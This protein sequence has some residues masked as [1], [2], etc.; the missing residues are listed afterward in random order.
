MILFKI[1][2]L[3]LF[4]SSCKD[5]FKLQKLS[6]SVRADYKKHLTKLP[7]ISYV[8]LFSKNP[9]IKEADLGRMLFNDT[10]LSRN[11]DVSCATCHLSNH[12]FA[13]GN[14]ISVGSMGKGGPTGD[15]VGKTFGH[16]T[17]SVNRKLDSDGFG[18]YSSRKMFRNSL[19]TVNVG[20]RASKANNSGLLWDG[21]FGD[22]AFQVL[23]PIHTPEELCGQNPLVKGRTNIFAKGGILFK[24]PITIYQS[25]FT[26]TYTGASSNEIG[27]KPTLVEGIPLYRKNGALTIPNRNECLALAIAKINKVDEYRALF[28]EIYKTDN[29]TDKHL[30]AALAMFVSTHVSKKSKYDRFIEG[31]NSLNE[32][33]LLGLTLFMND[34]GNDFVFDGKKRKGAGCIKCHTPPLFDKNEY[35]SLGV[36]SDPAS[37]LSRP[38]FQENFNSGFFNRSNAGKGN[39]TKCHIKGVSFSSSNLYAPDVGNANSTF[40]D[41]S[42]FKFRVPT[43][44]NVIATFPYFHHGS[45]LASGHEANSI[46][47]R[48]VIALSNAVKYHLRGPVDVKVYGIKNYPKQFF[49]QFYQRDPFIPLYRQNF[50]FEQ[51]TFEYDEFEIKAIV[52]F[53]A[54]GLKDSDS[55]KTGDLGNDVSHP[56]QVPSGLHPSITRDNGTQFDFPIRK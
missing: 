10:I 23:L 19:S 14:R 15:T 30:A 6:D 47:E 5:D 46:E 32:S 53:I 56:K 7:K 42:C 26:H 18:H 16:G 45:E 9:N 43:L 51:K 12:G 44:R 29:I 24:K 31:Q 11:N 54:F 1:L 2:F 20:Y 55:V 17:L 21:R 3:S 52:D 41:D 49:D 22:L 36:K 28:K 33:E 27:G 4:L 39:S 37:S 50:G 25:V 40:K 48:A 38:Q 8:D 35:Y 34:Y 13:D